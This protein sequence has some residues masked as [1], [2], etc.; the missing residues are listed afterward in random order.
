MCGVRCMYVRRRWQTSSCNSASSLS[1]LGPSALS[2]SRLLGPEGEACA[3]PKWRRTASHSHVSSAQRGRHSLCVPA[4]YVVWFLRVLVA[5]W[6]T[7]HWQ[8]CCFLPARPPVRAVVHSSVPVASQQHEKPVAERLRGHFPSKQYAPSFAAGARDWLPPA[9]R[10][11]RSR[12]RSPPLPAA[13]RR[14]LNLKVGQ[15]L[16]PCARI[17][18]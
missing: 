12:L 6:L 5:S 8:L 11:E 4:D 17:W 18:K 15:E 3:Q 14:L 7:A 16:S 1:T 10:Y 13:I 9:A 2:V